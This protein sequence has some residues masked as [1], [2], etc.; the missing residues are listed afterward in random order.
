MTLVLFSS[1]NGV[2]ILSPLSKHAIWFLSLRLKVLV[3]SYSFRSFLFLFLFCFFTNAQSCCEVSLRSWK[4]LF[5]PKVFAV[6]TF[7]LARWIWSGQS[8]ERE[9]KAFDKTSEGPG[10][11]PVS[12]LLLQFLPLPAAEKRLRI[13]C[14][15]RSRSFKRH[16]WGPCGEA[17]LLRFSQLLKKW[18]IGAF[19][20]LLSELLTVSSCSVCADRNNHEYVIGAEFSVVSLQAW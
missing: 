5:K 7:K 20:S 16:Q 14:K 1:D 6:F 15:L 10:A 3:L 2:F 13:K 19:S 12:L 11:R 17:A 9:K 18:E 8:T 4:V